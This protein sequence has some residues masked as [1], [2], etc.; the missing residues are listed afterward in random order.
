MHEGQEAA[1]CTCQCGHVST[2]LTGKPI[3]HAICYCNSC[4]TAGLG[5]AREPGAP[6]VVGEDGG[7]DYLLYRKDRV[8]PIAG[9]ELLRE[10]RLTPQSPT[11]R[12]IATCCNTPMFADFT[13][14]HW[15]SVYTGRLSGPV[16]PLDM[17][18]MTADRPEQAPLPAGAPT[19]PTQSP[20]F[21]IRLIAAWAAMGFRRPK[22]AW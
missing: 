5:F 7:T 20:K 17:R 22:V 21:M 2:T 9:G 16:P 15:L 13:K 8:G 19:Y 3:L 1:T 14:G 18:V 12:V 4:R 6:P 11:R 10:H